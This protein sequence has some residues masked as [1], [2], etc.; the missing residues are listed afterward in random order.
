MGEV[1]NAIV[2]GGASG[3]GRAIALRIAGTGT[4]VAILDIN[5]NNAEAAAAE[6]LGKGG[7]AVA[8]EADVAEAAGVAAAVARARSALGPVTILIH[9]AG[10][11]EFMPLLQMPD[12]NWERMIAVHLRGAF[13][14]CR[15]ALPDMIDAKWGRIVTIASVA[16]LGGGGPG[17]AHYAAAK[18]GMIALTKQ[19]ALEFGPM[20]VTA[21][22]IAPGLVDTPILGESEVTRDLIDRVTRRTPVGRIGNPEDIAAACAY[23]VSEEAAFFTGQVMSPNGGVYT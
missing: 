23:L 5:G 20:G 13:L 15:A 14:C 8:V 16:G 17:L 4:A 21:N 3:I 9:S 19:L 7:R 12:E 6:I 10:I 11:G 2:T 18:G 1:R 22:A